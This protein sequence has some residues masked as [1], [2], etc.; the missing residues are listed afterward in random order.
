[1]KKLGFIQEFIGSKLLAIK[2]KKVTRLK[3]TQSLNSAKNI[4]ILFDAIDPKQQKRV[5]DFVDILIK[6][7]GMQVQTLGFVSNPELISAFHGQNGFKYFS[8]KDFNWYGS[9]ENV[10]VQDFIN[11]PFN[12]FID[13]SLES[14]YPLEYITSLTQANFT[15]GQFNESKLS[16]DFMIDIKKDYT[17]DNLI[18]Q[19]HIYLSMIQVSK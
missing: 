2:S 18:K 12:I 11:E 17:L 16:Y 1:V 6:K 7:H 8:K 9:I 5:V 4:G 15:V 14:S 19:I 3:K 13:L 10:L